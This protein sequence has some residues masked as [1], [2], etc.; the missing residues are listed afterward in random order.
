VGHHRGRP[1]GR[2]ELVRGR[3]GDVTD[4]QLGRLPRAAI[5]IL[6]REMPVP[7]AAVGGGVRGLGRSEVAIR[8]DLVLA[9]VARGRS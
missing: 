2:Q 8:D 3:H 4:G 9:V 6:E 5:T 1:S 7:R